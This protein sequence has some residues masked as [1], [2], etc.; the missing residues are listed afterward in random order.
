MQTRETI[1]GVSQPLRGEFLRATAISEAVLYPIDVRL[2]AAGCTGI[3]VCQPA[4]AR[5][6]DR[7]VVR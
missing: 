2:P 7:S 5:A 1:E 6:T 4:V 3:T